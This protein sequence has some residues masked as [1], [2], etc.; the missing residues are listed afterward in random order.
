MNSSRDPGY[1]GDMTATAA[2]ADLESADALDDHWFVA[3]HAAPTL[4]PPPNSAPPD[5]H[6]DAEDP[7]PLDRWFF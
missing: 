6:A 1:E 3:P 2:P 7:D 5:A 4:A